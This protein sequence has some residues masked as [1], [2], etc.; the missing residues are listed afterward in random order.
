MLRP[1]CGTAQ[2]VNVGMA[3]QKPRKKIGD[4]IGDPHPVDAMPPISSKPPSPSDEHAKSRTGR[5]LMIAVALIALAVGGL[6]LVDRIRDRPPGPIPPQEPA[7]ALIATPVPPTDTP[8][9]NREHPVTPPPAPEVVN[10]ETLTSPPRAGRVMPSPTPPA[11]KPS[12]PD[13]G[14]AYLVQVGIFKSRAN[15]Q[16]LQKQLQ[17]AGIQAHLET[18]VQLG[19]FK[20]KRE[21]D[22]A[23]S[24]AR[25]L[26]IDAV[27][28]TSR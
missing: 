9:T 16:A 1:R 11:A 4:S 20:D 6:A 27:L 26:G 15:A 17:R 2:R 10:N 22:K 7:Q 25:K 14:K 5:K 8:A 12:S 23:L 3:A 19:P 24:S 13:S 18:R 28:V 21:A